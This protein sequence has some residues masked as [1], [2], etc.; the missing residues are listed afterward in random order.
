[1]AFLFGSSSSGTSTTGPVTT[2]PGSAPYG[3]LLSFSQQLLNNP[4]QGMQP[5]ANAGM[6]EINSSYGNIPQVVSSAMAKRGYGSSG[7]MGDTMYKTQLGRLSSLSQ[8][9]GQMA[10]LTSQR[11]MSAAQI[12]QSLMGHTT[13]TTSST[14]N[15]AAAFSSLGTIMSMLDGLGGTS[16]GGF[17]NGST[18]EVN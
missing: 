3:D 17:G 11:Q 15:P 12:M 1:M 2:G 7:D 18:Y 5:I 8:F 4:S 14:V 16:G 10:N 6:E 13:N 9:Q